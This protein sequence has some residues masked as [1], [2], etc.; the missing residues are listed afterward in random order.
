MDDVSRRLKGLE[1][2]HRPRQPFHGPMIVLHNMIE[3]HA[4]ADGDPGMVDP[5]GSLNRGR[6]APTLV[7]RNGLWAS[8]MTNRLAQEC[9]SL[10]KKSTVG[11]ALST[12]R[13]K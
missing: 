3:I 5:V 6:G 2:Q 1:S 4:V 8:V 12:A 13:Y 11:P 7:N 10:N 9:G